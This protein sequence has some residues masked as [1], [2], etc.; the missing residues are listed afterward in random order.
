[1]IYKDV[2]TQIVV[3]EALKNSTGLI[4]N[5][6]EAL[7]AAYCDGIQHALNRVEDTVF[8]LKARKAK[9]LADK[10]PIT[11]DKLVTIEAWFKVLSKEI[12]KG[13]KCQKTTGKTHTPT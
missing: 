1:M 7:G 9:A 12:M 2:A 3:S 13:S 8:E 6:T 11:H 10:D 4:E 5:L